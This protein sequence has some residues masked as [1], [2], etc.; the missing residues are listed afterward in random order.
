MPASLACASPCSSWMRAQPRIARFG[1]V[2]VGWGVSRATESTPSSWDPSKASTNQSVARAGY[3]R[4][5]DD[6][7]RAAQVRALFLRLVAKA[8]I[9]SSCC[10]IVD[11]GATLH[12]G[13]EA[14]AR[15]VIARL[16]TRNVWI[17]GQSMSYITTVA[18]ANECIVNR[19]SRF[20]GGWWAAISSRAAF[21]RP[22]LR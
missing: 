20:A 1:G 12:I 10:R 16:R 3:P 21:G 7:S 17:R 5:C 13:A 14:G 18:V 22:L 8:S 11:V 19:G 9:S 15:A 4:R 6:G 2:F